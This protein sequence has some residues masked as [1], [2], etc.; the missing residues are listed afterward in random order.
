MHFE[1]IYNKSLNIDFITKDEALLLFNHAPT[2]ELMFIANQIKNKLKKQ[3]D[4]NKVGWIIDR[5]VNITNVCI[6][7]CKFC[8]F[9]RKK[10]DADTYITSVE[11]YRKKIIELYNTG[12]RQ[13][14]LQGGLH[15]DLK[16]DFYENLFKTLKTEFPDLKLHAL[17]PPEI[18]HI[19]K[20]SGIT[21]EQTLKR[22][23]YAGLDSLPGAGAEILVDRVRKIVSPAKCST[24]EWLEVMKIAHIINIPTS[25]TMMFGHVETVEER[26]EHL[27]KLRNLQALKPSDSYG[28]VTFIPW[29]FQSEGTK[30]GKD[31][32][33]KFIDAEEYIRTIALSRIILVNIANI[34]TSWLTVGKE[35][36]Q[37][38]LHGGANDFGSI[39]IEE[40]VVSAAGATNKFNKS[41]IQNAITEA[42][43]IPCMRDVKYV[44][45]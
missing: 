29:P 8:N 44:F 21:F 12:G 35:T 9:C 40:N 19:S 11:D 16:I 33:I 5:N 24:D 3:D 7:F 14:L 26:I 1:K 25:A 2:S 36:A 37:I 43:F 22:L 10:S 28:F 6:S 27:M 13:L 15:P 18:V 41:E 31:F 45:Q 39:M 4:F 23:I 30:I 20:I 17:G 34:Q 38:S 42:G 32:E